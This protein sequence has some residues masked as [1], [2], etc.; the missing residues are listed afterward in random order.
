MTYLFNI[1]SNY[2]FLAQLKL[3]QPS[4]GVTDSPV[5][6]SN[7]RISLLTFHMP[8]GVKASCVFS[9]FTS[10]KLESPPVSGILSD[11]PSHYLPSE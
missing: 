2:Y 7:G 9:H 5:T 10:S 1:L 8:Q 3:G 4:P 6:L 11:Y